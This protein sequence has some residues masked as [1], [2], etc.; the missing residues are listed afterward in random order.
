MIRKIDGFMK[1]MYLYPKVDA[2]EYIT[3][4]HLCVVASPEMI[5]ISSVPIE[6]DVVGD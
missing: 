3:S 1:R 5:G 2:H 4:S 6:P